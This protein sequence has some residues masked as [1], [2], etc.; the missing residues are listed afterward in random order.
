MVT[1]QPPRPVI[2]WVI[3]VPLIALALAAA[4]GRAVALATGSEPFAI[5]YHL[6]PGPAVE[7][8]RLLDRW[9]AAQAGLTWTHILT[10]SVVLT[11]APAQFVPRIRQQYLRFHRWAGRVALV[12][13]LPAGLSGLLLQ[14]RSPYGGLLA[15]S[16][17]VS[18]GALFLA[19]GARAYHAI[20][21]G[22]RDRHREWM[23]RLLAVG[24]GVGVVRVV[25]LP[26]ILVTGRR[27]L[28]LV[29]VAFWLG[30]ALPILAGE[31]WIRTT[32]SKAPAES[33]R[34]SPV[35]GAA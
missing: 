32:R 29:G 28:E 20:R 13:A 30:F 8:A 23:I 18:A 1:L 2:V 33:R 12:A 9:F 7:D 22:E 26:L 17:I 16:A 3:V 6:F 21:R 27:P 34:A 14:A 10:G 11:L 19:A 4:G 35:I 25:A 31:W 15:L 24:L 5:L